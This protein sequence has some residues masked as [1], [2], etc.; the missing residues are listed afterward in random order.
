MC[1][2]NADGNGLALPPGSAVVALSGTLEPI[3]RAGQ[4]LLTAPEDVVVRDGDLV[5][6]IVGKRRLLRR[7]WTDG[8]N[9]Q[10]TSINPVRPSNP[11]V[12]IKSSW[13]SPRNDATRGATETSSLD[14]LMGHLDASR[15]W[16]PIL[17]QPT[18]PNRAELRRGAGIRVR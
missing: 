18:Q 17:L 13:R 7:A 14:A 12:A 16:A 4:W 15:G 2:E 1:N 11:E 10:L 5:V 6:A 3:V 8:A 9:W